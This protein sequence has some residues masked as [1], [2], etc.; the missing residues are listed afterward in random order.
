MLRRSVVVLAA[1]LLVAGCG[2]FNPSPTLR[3]SGQPRAGSPEP[4][5]GLGWVRISPDGLEGVE[6]G[7]VAVGGDGSLLAIGRVVGPIP[8]DGST[9]PA[10]VWT[11]TDGRSWARGAESAA[12]ESVRPRWE[13]VPLDL[14]WTDAGFVAVGMSQFDDASQADAAAWFSPDGSSWQPVLVDEGGGRTID[15]VVRSDHGLVAF[16]AA[17]Y[18]FHAGFG[19][20][21]AMWTSPDGR[22]W[23]RRK[24]DDAPPRGVRLRDVTRVADGSWIAIARGEVSEGDDG[25]ARRAVTDGI[26]RSADGLHWVPVEG[27]P[28]DLAELIATADGVAALGRRADPSG[29]A[30]VPVIWRS[31]DGTT[32]TSAALPRPGPLPA[33]TSLDDAVLASGPAGWL[34]AADRDG[35]DAASVIWRSTDGT[36]WTASAEGPWGNARIVRAI[37]LA[38]G[39]LVT[40]EAPGAGGIRVPI[41]W[42]VTP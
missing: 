23:T 2:S 20:G 35:G 17:R 9:P 3:P 10:S 31:T 41:T 30:D 4:T 32:W 36:A 25:L 13:R 34:I 12:F 1:A 42:F 38:G 29:G 37:A 24:D 5:P 33:G 15:E 40:G 18:D 26:W 11:S 39:I 19:D 8:A 16:G 22:S 7:P 28:L 27:S 14:L 6:L 21:T